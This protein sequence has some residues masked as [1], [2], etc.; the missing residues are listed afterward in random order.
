MS[1][2]AAPSTIV[3][4]REPPLLTLTLN[5]P[6]ALNAL[7]PVLLEELN[8]ALRDAEADPETRVLLITGAPRG[9][10]RPNFSAGADLKA[11]GGPSQSPAGEPLAHTLDAA[12]ELASGV[13]P[14][15]QSRFNEVFGYLERMSTPSI[16][17]VDGICTTGGLELILACDLRVVGEAVQI[18]DWH[19]KNLAAIG[20]AGVTTRLPRLIGAGR[21][22]EMLWTGRPVGGD[23]AVRIGLANSVHPSA[24]LL[25]RAKELASSIA[26]MSPF[27][28][29]ASKAVVNASAQQETQESIRYAELW[30]SLIALQ[31]EAAGTPPPPSPLGRERS[32]QP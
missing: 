28:V 16:A 17:V 1:A 27:A 29:A 11:S 20:G 26:A 12:R 6:E 8:A 18:S 32:A 22:K 3:V 31:K 13:G 2:P 14:A 5:R 4:E 10:G 23:E 15:H 24:E 21:A 25:D 30:S 19:T 9:G 7:S